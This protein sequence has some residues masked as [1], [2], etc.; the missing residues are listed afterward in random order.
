MSENGIQSFLDSKY[1]SDQSS[2]KYVVQSAICDKRLELERAKLV[3]QAK[4]LPNLREKKDLYPK[5]SYTIQW[6][7]EYRIIFSLPPVSVLIAEKSI[8]RS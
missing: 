8:G 4:T 7:W 6:F 5:Y 2:S 3:E 1:R